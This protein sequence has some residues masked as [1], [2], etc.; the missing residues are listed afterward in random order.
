LSKNIIITPALSKSNGHIPKGTVLD[1]NELNNS[2]SLLKKLDKSSITI[3][4]TTCVKDIPQDEI[5]HVNDH[6][7]CSGENPL[8]GRQQELGIDFIDMSNVY[9]KTHNGIVTESCGERL[10][11][12]FSFPSTF[13]AHIV[14]LARTLGFKKITAKLINKPQ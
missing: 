8:V 2:I 1:I 5:Y 4:D 12:D 11:L 3:Y 6:I 10:N 14:I 7:N 9:E 13:L